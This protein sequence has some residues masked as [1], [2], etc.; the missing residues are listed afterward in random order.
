MPYAMAMHEN[1]VYLA[2]TDAVYAFDVTHPKAPRLVTRILLDKPPADFTTSGLVYYNGTL[3]SSAG[4]E[5]MYIMKV[6]LDG[7]LSYSV[8]YEN[9]DCRDL[10]DLAIYKD[11]LY[12][13]C[14]DKGMMMF[15]VSGD[16]AS[17][18]FLGWATV[19]P[20]K[21]SAQTGLFY[22]ELLLDAENE[23]LYVPNYT[24]GIYILDISSP[25][26]PTLLS[27]ITTASNV[28][29][30]TLQDDVLYAALYN[31]NYGISAFDV[32]DPA[33]PALLTHLD[34][35]SAYRMLAIGEFLFT[36]E[37]SNLKVIRIVDSGE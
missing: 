14:E 10:S 22:H 18:T 12:V 8:K 17:P 34:T 6:S 24:Q 31:E 2:D 32:R 36:S 30:I 7:G 1:M 19:L 21:P 35:Q 16:P 37:G 15:D 33:T 20:E 11:T 5:G 4:Y 27:Q 3:Y 23:R 13:I 29:A 26:A 28:S 9:D 25:H